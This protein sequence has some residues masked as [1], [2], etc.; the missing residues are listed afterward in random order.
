[1]LKITLTID[2]QDVSKLPFS[3]FKSM[4]IQS[5]TPTPVVSKNE[6]VQRRL[7]QRPLVYNYHPGVRGRK[8][9]I[10]MS[11]ET[12]NV[13]LKQITE[14][15]WRNGSW[16]NSLKRAIASQRYHGSK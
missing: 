7:L 2:E 13:T 11:L 8:I 6:P 12:N 14:T 9:D 3:A 5:L 15:K 10:G 1:M 16:Q 4:D